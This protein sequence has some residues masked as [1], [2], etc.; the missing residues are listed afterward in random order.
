MDVTGDT[1]DLLFKG[2]NTKFNE[3][4]Q[5]TASH[6]QKVAMELKSSGS[7]EVYGWLSTLPQMR[8]WLGDRVLEAV[9]KSDYVIKN[10]KFE[11]TIVVRREDIEDDRLGICGPQLRI[12]A[13]NAASHPDEWSSIF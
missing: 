1:I 2:F 10:R 9:S 4:H 3:F 12:M 7:E 13:H 6:W 11:A 5:Q 8:E